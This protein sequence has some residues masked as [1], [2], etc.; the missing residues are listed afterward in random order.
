MAVPYV[1]TIDLTLPQYVVW[2]GG[3][4]VWVT[5]HHEEAAHEARCQR[6]SSGLG[7]EVETVPPEHEGADAEAWRLGRIVRVPPPRFRSLPSKA[8]R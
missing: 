2:V 7:A 8:W 1:Y 5:Q 4:A 3:E 6:R